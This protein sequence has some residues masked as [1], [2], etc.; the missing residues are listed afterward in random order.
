MSERCLI[1]LIN[2][3]LSDLAGVVGSFVAEERW[4]DGA[5]FC[6]RCRARSTHQAKREQLQMEHPLHGAVHAETMAL[7]L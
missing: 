2:T 6:G 4:S 3:F 7:A 5:I 1:G